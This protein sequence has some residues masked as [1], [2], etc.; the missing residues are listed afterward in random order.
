MKVCYYAWSSYN[1]FAIEI[2][3][4]ISLRRIEYN[5]IFV[6]NNFNEKKAI[7]DTFQ[8]VEVY[9]ATEFME[10]NYKNFTESE[11]IRCEKQYNI[12][13]LWSLILSDRFLYDQP[14]DYV[15]RI[16]TGYLLFFEFIFKK[17]HPDYFF[18]EV[19]AVFSS[20]AAYFIG[21]AYGVKYVAPMASR[22]HG[23]S[24]HY[25]VSDPFQL[26]MNFDQ[27]YIEIT[28]ND[29]YIN[30][31]RRYLKDFESK[32]LKP[33]L[34]SYTGIKPKL[35]LSFI[36]EFLFFL[37]EACRS[38]NKYDYINRYNYKSHLNPMIFFFRYL[39][40]KRY[41]L[42]D[43][44]DLRRKY[45]FV[46]LHYQ[47][48]ASTLVCAPKYEKQLFLIDSLSKSIPADTL[49][50]VKEHYAL[51]GHKKESFYKEL[52]K[53]PNVVLLDPWI[54]SHLMI[55]GAEAVVALTGTAGFEAVLYRKPI[56]LLGRIFYENAPGVIK[57]DDMYGVYIKELT[58][59]KLPSREQIEQ[60]LAE[61]FRTMYKGCVYTIIPSTHS[62]KNIKDV[63]NSF[64]IQLMRLEEQKAGTMS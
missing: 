4:E 64:F 5:A 44:P 18:N 11:F 21:T 24:H 54:D 13:S 58:K 17:E 55:K 48:E 43:L 50:Y 53:Y 22:T 37:W 59:W 19:I 46:P 36:K 15:I 10:K 38:K 25:F 29:I 62:S 39:R 63:A 2:H 61:C 26:N 60:Y 57:L 9:S 16:A 14:H 42:H 47:P 35:R 6:V 23:S 56:F 45:V 1:R 33:E 12:E 27:T 8:D 41:F 3:R 40:I 7:L 51:L 20:Y 28:K 34:M 30:K 52:S 31:A 32:T 49:I